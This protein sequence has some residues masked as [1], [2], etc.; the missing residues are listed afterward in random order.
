MKLKSNYIFNFSPRYTALLSL[1][2]CCLIVS[3]TPIF[4]KWSEQEIGAYPTVFYRFLFGFFVYGLIELSSLE[5]SQKT[6]GDKTNEL[7]KTDYRLTENIPVLALI[8]TCAT[9]NQ[10]CWALSL[11]Q[12]SVGNSALLH[13]LSPIF[14]ALFAWLFLSKKIEFQLLVAMII[15]VSGLFVLTAGDFQVSITKLQGDGFALLSA[16][17]F[18]GYLIL[19]EDLRKYLGSSTILFW[20]CLTGST[21]VLPFLFFDSDHLFPTSVSGWLAILGMTS[22]FVIGHWLLASS[23]AILS[24]TFVAIVLLLDPFLSSIQAWIFFAEKL[25]TLEWVS[26]VIVILG[27]YLAITT[28]PEAPTK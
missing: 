23:L 20:R 3:L 12:T 21:L 18:A 15:S 14:T 5:A 22:T 8:G 1:V 26:F 28:D 24:S 10:I 17:F 13:S 27:V 16:F 4:V 6:D 9:G 7:D 2:I 25:S 11:T 19:V